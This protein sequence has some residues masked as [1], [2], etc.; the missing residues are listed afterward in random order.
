MILKRS[1]SHVAIAAHHNRLSKVS[2]IKTPFET[3]T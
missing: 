2:G 1:I 3:T